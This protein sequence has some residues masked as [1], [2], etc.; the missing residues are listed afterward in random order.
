MTFFVI[1]LMCIDTKL[2]FNY[3]IIFQFFNVNFNKI[4]FSMYL[5]KKNT[6]DLHDCGWCRV[7]GFTCSIQAKQRSNDAQQLSAI[8][9]IPFF[10]PDWKTIAIRLIAVRKTS[11]S[12]HHEAQLR[13][14]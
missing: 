5:K 12:G 1:V 14:L 8:R 9:F 3:Q 10:H 7:G 2:H 6:H 13:A 11:G 4:V